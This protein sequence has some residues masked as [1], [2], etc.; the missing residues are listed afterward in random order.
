MFSMTSVLFLIDN[1]ANHGA[2]RTLLYIAKYLKKYGLVKD[3][4]LDIL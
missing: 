2:Q 3:V 4:A 1:L